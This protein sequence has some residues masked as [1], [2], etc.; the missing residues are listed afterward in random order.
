MAWRSALLAP[1]AV[2]AVMEY[3]D[4]LDEDSTAI[5]ELN[6]SGVIS[7]DHAKLALTKVELEEERNKSRR[8]SQQLNEANFSSMRTRISREK[9]LTEE[10]EKLASVEDENARYVEERAALQAQIRHLEGK[11][12]ELQ[13]ANMALQ[14]QL[15]ETVDFAAAALPAALIAGDPVA[16]AGAGS[17]GELTRLRQELLES[18]VARE[19]LEGQLNDQKMRLE[20]EVEVREST[21]R[22]LTEAELSLEATSEYSVKIEDLDRENDALKMQRDAALRDAEHSVV[23][24]P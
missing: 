14:Q 1:D 20:Y 12:A 6:P 19:D 13:A 11:V 4:E 15:S 16:E 21:E 17:I 23:C 3:A 9:Q 7:P 10:L 22:L 8:L 2:A 18:E 24:E 5:A